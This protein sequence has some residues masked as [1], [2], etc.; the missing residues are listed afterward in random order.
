LLGLR[1]PYEAVFSGI[2]W[3]TAGVYSQTVAR[4]LEAGLSMYEGEAW[5][6]MDEPEDLLRLEGSSGYAPTSPLA[7][8]RS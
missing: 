4:A 3:S 2:E 8:R 5:Y 6:D 1:G 7:P